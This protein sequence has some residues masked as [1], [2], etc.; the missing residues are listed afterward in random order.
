MWSAWTIARPS[1]AEEEEETGKG[2][3]EMSRRIEA[4]GSRPVALR[5]RRL[6]LEKGAWEVEAEAA[7]EPMR[8]ELWEKAKTAGGLALGLGVEEHV[9]APLPRSR[10]HQGVVCQR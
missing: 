1:A 4:A 7:W 6:T 9:D 10:R 2:R 3:R 5:M 8:R